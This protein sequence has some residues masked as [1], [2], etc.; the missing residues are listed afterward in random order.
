MIRRPPRS[1]LVPYTTLFRSHPIVYA[2]D[3]V[4]V[5]ENREALPRAWLVHEARAATPEEALRL[6]ASGAVDP[7]RV[8]L[9]DGEPPAVS[10]PRSEEHTSRTPVTPISRMPAS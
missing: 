9:V 6:L 8:A 1:T 3:R 7:R 4:R 2:D 10:A 5:L